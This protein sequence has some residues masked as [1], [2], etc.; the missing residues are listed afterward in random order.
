MNKTA[1]SSSV[2]QLRAAQ[3][4]LSVPNNLKDCFEAGKNVEFQLPGMCRDGY[5]KDG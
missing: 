4:I 2:T 1:F 3:K 5:R